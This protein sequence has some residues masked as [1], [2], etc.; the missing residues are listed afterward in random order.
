MGIA[1]IK[2]SSI[3]A[4]TVGVTFFVAC[5]SRTETGTSATASA[6]TP[7][8]ATSPPEPTR[9]EIVLAS[10][11]TDPVSL[12]VNNGYIYWVNDDLDTE[13]GTVL[14]MPLGGGPPTTIASHQYELTADARIAVYNSN[15]YWVRT[16][17]TREDADHSRRSLVTASVNGGTVRKL[18]STRFFSKGLAAD[19]SGVYWAEGD[20]VKHV[21]LT[22]GK[23]V[24]L[25]GDS[26]NGLATDL[27]IDGEYVYWSQVSEDLKP[28]SQLHNHLWRAP[29]D[30]GGAV[31]LAAFGYTSPGIRGFAIDD[32]SVYVA[33]ATD[34]KGAGTIAVVP[35][36]GGPARTLV[37]VVRLWAIASDTAY[38]Y[39]VTWGR[40]AIVARV[41]KST[42]EALVLASNQSNPSSIAVDESFVYWTTGDTGEAGTGTV[43]KIRK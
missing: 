4:V 32:A 7:A 41:S 3:I 19:A 39:V 31:E 28:G 11:Q 15:V 36:S 24:T 33:D 9:T 37:T 23:V 29:R 34:G 21:S 43:K 8:P 18:A 2:S 35:K 20:A 5:N 16:E 14:R 22:G 38:L 12:V 6:T 42:G 25:A 27:H 10:Q 13:T 1:R 30:G 26:A 40:P 17:G